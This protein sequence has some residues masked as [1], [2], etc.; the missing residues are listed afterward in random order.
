MSYQAMKRHGRILSALDL[1]ERSQSE[2]AESCTVSTIRHFGK[3]KTVEP[4]KRLVVAK[5]CQGAGRD[6][7][8]EHRSS[9]A[10]NSQS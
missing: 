3:G 8:T 1:S 5:G 9:R 4:L 6:E 10:W 2:K 7:Q